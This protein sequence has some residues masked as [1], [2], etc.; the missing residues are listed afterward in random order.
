[1]YQIAFDY[2]WLIGNPSNTSITLLGSQYLNSFCYFGESGDSGAMLNRIARLMS[3]DQS[4]L[5]SDQYYVTI[6]QLL[7]SYEV[8]NQLDRATGMT[9]NV[10][11]K[12]LVNEAYIKR[13]GRLLPYYWMEYDNGVIA[14]VWYEVLTK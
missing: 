10:P 12:E 7:M 3:F 14:I 6:N 9:K 11:F 13:V 5:I 4:N 1:M 8:P 2:S